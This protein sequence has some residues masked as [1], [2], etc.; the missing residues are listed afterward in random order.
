MDFNIVLTFDTMSYVLKFEKVLKKQK[1]AVKLKPVPREFSS[2][3][4]TCA[5]IYEKDLDKALEICK[6][7]NIKYDEIFRL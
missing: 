6:K 5:Y 4:G 2:S 1:M 3:C 7:E